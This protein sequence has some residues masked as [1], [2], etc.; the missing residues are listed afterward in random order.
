MPFGSDLFEDYIGQRLLASSTRIEAKEDSQD[1][2]VRWQ[3]VQE[4]K[5]ALQNENEEIFINILNDRLRPFVEGQIEE[6]VK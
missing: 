4:K 1:D 2:V 3:K 5:K 6:F